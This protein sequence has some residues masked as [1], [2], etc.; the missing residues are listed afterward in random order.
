MMSDDSRSN[1]SAGER[2][3][4]FIA[5]PL[6]PGVREIMGDVE[7]HLKAHDWPVKWVDPDLAHITLKFLGDT[8]SERVPEIRR[9]LQPVAGR[10]TGAEV[11]TGRI[12]AFPSMNRARVIWLGLDGDLSPT[13]RL[14][15]DVDVAMA[16]LGFGREERPFRPHITLGRLRHGKTVPR[17]FERIVSDLPVP[18]IAVRLDRVQLIRS[19]LDRSGPTYTTLAE[20]QL[21]PAAKEGVAAPV[22]IIEHG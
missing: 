12:G 17:D 9:A 11:T 8:P 19:V 15:R 5:V 7:H 21:G 16:G 13:D 18:R 14:A 4:L 6:P 20:W 10:H 22:E 1:S 3:R 2:W